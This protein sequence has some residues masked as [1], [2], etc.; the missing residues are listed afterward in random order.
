MRQGEGPVARLTGHLSVPVSIQSLVVLRVLFGA[1]LVWDCW[2]YIRHDRIR[3]YYVDVEMT[4]PHFGLEFVQPLP[5]PHIHW[6]WLGVG[7]SAF[8]VM[9]GLF[10]RA[11]IVAFILI[12]GYFFLLDRAQY[13]NH[14]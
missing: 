3:R 4:F 9:I 11:A 13:L 1:I 7:V 10:Y 12:F 2:R 6:L 5:A 8:L 14:T